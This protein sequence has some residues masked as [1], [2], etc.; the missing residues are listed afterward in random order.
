MLST[1]AKPFGWLMMWLYEFV[2]N[3]G[4]AVILFGL[5]VKLILLPFMAKSKRS[6]MRTSRLQPQIQELQK[7]HGGNQQKLNA[8]IQK[9]YKEEKINPMSG[10][11]WTLIPFPILIALYEAIRYPLTIMMGVPKALIEEGGA[12]FNKLQEMGFSSNLSESYLQIAQTK[13]ISEH[14][15]AFAGL[16]DKLKQIDYSFLGIDLGTEPQWNFLWKT[17]WSD[18]S[19][20]L[21]GLG[22]FLIPIIAAALTY[23]S[24]KISQKINPSSVDPNNPQANSMKSMLIVMPIITL[25][26]AFMMPAALGVYWIASSFFSILQDILLTS[27]YKKK[28]IEEDAAMQERLRQREEELEAKRI[29]TERLRA[30]NATAVNPNTSKRKQHK[31]ERTEQEEKAAQWEKQFKP[32]K[33]KETPASQVGNRRYARGRAYDPNRFGKNNAPVSETVSDEAAEKALNPTSEVSEN[34]AKNV[35]EAAEN[36]VLAEKTAETAAEIDAEE[37]FADDF[38]DDTD[39]EEDEET[40]KE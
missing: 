16:S 31:K 14:F 1:I 7:K 6:M 19:V 28:M 21:P 12:I 15:D 37:D 4:I 38:E 27:I 24:S 13:F 17:D 32:A 30:A 40:E 26:F 10:C 3:Y 29:E 20:W 36:T 5:I 23:L 33:E 2:G 8:E 34:E 11:I 35:S 22:L 9:L 39:A 25:W 18:P